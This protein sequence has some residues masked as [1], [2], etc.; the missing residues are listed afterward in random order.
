MM[1][2]RIYY[3]ERDKMKQLRYKITISRRKLDALYNS[4]TVKD[5]NTKKRVL[6]KENPTLVKDC[7]RQGSYH[8]IPMPSQYILIEFL[9]L[10]EW[11]RKQSTLKKPL[12]KRKCRFLDAGS[13]I[14]NILL[15]ADA[16][17]LSTQYTGIEFNKP[18]L[19]LSKKILGHSKERFKLILGD[20]IT[21]KD[22]NNFDIVYYYCPFH[23]PLLGIY[24]EELLE[25]KISPGTI[26]AYHLK[27]SHEI[28]KDNRFTRII[29]TINIG[30]G[31]TLSSR[32]LQFYVKTSTGP[33]T[34]SDISKFVC[35]NLPKKYKA[36]INKHIAKYL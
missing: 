1:Y 18:T 8:Y 28:H 34:S 27:Q 11:I 6:Y 12:I 2:G 13:G 7:C 4:T 35:K 9:A 36:R 16:A 3:N 29:L 22:Y 5:L 15:L 21:Y 26:L 25:D 10:K 19:E 17:N 31:K 14:G 20:I 30:T 32:P 33:R 23:N 24:F